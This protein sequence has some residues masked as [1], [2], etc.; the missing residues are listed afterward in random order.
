LVLAERIPV[1]ENTEIR[2]S[3][4]KITPNE[5]A[6]VKGI[7]RWTIMLEPREQR[8]FRIAYQV[9][10][11]PTLIFDVRRKQMHAPPAPSPASPHAPRP[12][13]KMDFEERILHF[14]SAF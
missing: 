9:E 1:S 12:A 8:E 3:N 7:V 2:V 5:K 11:P 4:V 10:Y 6:D 13:K 14:E